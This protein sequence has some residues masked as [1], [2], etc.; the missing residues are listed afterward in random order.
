MRLVLATD[1]ISPVVSMSDAGERLT[2]Q[3]AIFEDVIALDQQVFGSAVRAG[4]EPTP[5]VAAFVS[6]LAEDL[7][8]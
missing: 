5:A 7:R 2:E 3:F 6:R 8:R 1:A 4:R